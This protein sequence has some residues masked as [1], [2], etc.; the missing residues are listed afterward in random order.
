MMDD[1]SNEQKHLGVTHAIRARLNFLDEKLWKRF[2]ARRLEFIDTLDLSSKK[3]SEQEK[4]IKSVSESL[5]IEF[6][7]GLDYA[8]D[9]EKLVRAAIQSARRNRKRASKSQRQHSDVGPVD[10]VKKPRIFQSAPFSQPAFLNSYHDPQIMNMRQPLP[11]FSES[12]FSNGVSDN[13]SIHH[14]NKK[15]FISE[16]SKLN[17]DSQDDIY[18]LNYSKT[19]SFSPFDK[20][21][22]AIDNMI[23]PRIKYDSMPTI[24]KSLEADTS[25]NENMAKSI[26][27][28]Y[29]EI[30]KTCAE[31]RSKKTKNL[32][33]LG[34]AV[35]L[36][37]ITYLFEKSFEAASETSTE[38]L[39]AKLK[40]ELYLARFYKELDFNVAERLSDE[41]AVISLYT[42]LGGCVKDFGFEAIVYP[43][44]ELFYISLIKEY[45]LISKNSKPFT[46]INETSKKAHIAQGEFKGGLNS[47][48][49]VASDIQKSEHSTISPPVKLPV[50][51]KKEASVG[52]QVS[53]SYNFGP[54]RKQV[55]LKFASSSLEFTYPQTS[56]APRFI[57][58]LENARSA[59]RL[60]LRDDSILGL[61]NILTGMIINSDI[62]LE[63]IFKTQE[64]IELEIFTQRSKAIP[65]YEITSAVIPNKYKDDSSKI[66]LP[67]PYDNRTHILPPPLLS[68]NTLNPLDEQ[69]R[70]NFHPHDE[71]VP[72]PVLPRFQ[73]LL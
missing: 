64:K 2:S 35:I 48:A 10:N 24:N 12:D 51:F 21:R 13:E 37:C 22:L 29:F 28:H 23:K 32:E 65:I 56:A 46:Y 39:T 72:Q 71:A 40:K 70:F 4:E 34:E 16:I 1:T 62:D 38:Y 52:S 7:Y 50:E 45:P 19:K 58:I 3:A 5:R 18:D 41:I 60:S 63:K 11:R 47:L 61:K 53:G 33:A 36:S 14:S 43:L 42:L 27:L 8:P 15:T 31:A 55:I 49:A 6:N 30:S 68:H 25:A 69:S 73:P 67:P 20:S 26:I 59:F 54:G 44:C 57:E 66:I 9:F 17:S